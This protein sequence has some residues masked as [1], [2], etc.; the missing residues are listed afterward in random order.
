MCVNPFKMPNI[1]TK[2]EHCKAKTATIHQIKMAIIKSERVPAPA[3]CHQMN[4]GPSDPTSCW[5]SS[6]R[7]PRCGSH[8][9]STSHSTKCRDNGEVCHSAGVPALP[10]GFHYLL[11]QQRTAGLRL[12]GRLPGTG[13]ML[14]CFD[15]DRDRWGASLS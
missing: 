14:V 1:G 10:P 7:D 13:Q 5:L 8:S 4:Q 11:S 15:P 3:S 9:Y 12:T 6:R 2:V